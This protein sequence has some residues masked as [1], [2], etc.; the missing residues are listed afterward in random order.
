MG[1][2]GPHILQNR[3]PIS[4]GF[5]QLSHGYML[6]CSKSLVSVVPLHMCS[7]TMSGQPSTNVS[8]TS[9]IGQGGSGT[10]LVHELPPFRGFR[11]EK[12]LQESGSI[13]QVRAVGFVCSA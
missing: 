4:R 13:V 5:C 12:L 1:P 3:K 11:L 7:K 10:A 6:S 2:D 8:Y 9:S